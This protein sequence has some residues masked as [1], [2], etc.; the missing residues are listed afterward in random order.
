M[1]TLLRGYG[2]Q[3][4]WTFPGMIMPFS[5]LLCNP[6]PVFIH[7]EPLCFH[8]GNTKRKTTGLVIKRGRYGVPFA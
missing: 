3:P 2:T 5:S 8:P 6:F 1:D 4:R 7:F